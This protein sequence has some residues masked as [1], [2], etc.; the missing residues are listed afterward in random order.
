M[1]PRTDT[2][3][4]VAFASSADEPAFDELVRRHQQ[5]VFQTCLRMLGNV[6]EA[7]DAA[8]ATLIV[9]MKKA[10]TL[11]REGSLGGWLHAVA[12]RIAL[13]A[14]R[15]RNC[16]AKSQEA[17]AWQM[18]AC[19]AEPADV[20]AVLGFLDEELGRLS[21][22]QKQ[23][24][25]LR[26]LEGHSEKEAAQMAGCP[27]G[28]IGRRASDGIARL[29]LA[30]RGVTLGVSTL[31]GVLAVE[32]SATISETILPSLLT[33]VKSV[34]TTRATTT[35]VPAKA[36]MLA[37]GAMKAMFI[38]K[39]KMA[40]VVGLAIMGAAVGWFVTQS[41]SEKGVSEP[42]MPR[43]AVLVC[44][45]DCDLSDARHALARRGVHVFILGGNRMV[46]SPMMVPAALRCRRMPAR[47]YVE[48]IAADLGRRTVWLREGTVAILEQDVAANE[49]E[50]LKK[51]LA[52]RDIDA[53]R[54]AV[55]R[56]GRTYT[57]EAL[58]LLMA[59]AS[60]RE[61]TVA[62]EARDGLE[63]L[64]WG[65]ALTLDERAWPLFEAQ[66]ADP[67]AS[68]SSPEEVAMTG[69]PRSLAILRQAMQDR[70][71]RDECIR[72]L[73][74]VA[75]TEARRELETLLRD[76]DVDTRLCAILAMLNAGCETV[77][78]ALEKELREAS[79]YV[80]QQL[81]GSI[82]W[83]PLGRDKLSSEP[84]KSYLRRTMRQTTDG[85][86]RIMAGSSLCATGNREGLAFVTSI[87]RTCLDYPQETL[88]CLALALVDN[89]SPEALLL[90]KE[91]FLGAT[92]S[93]RNLRGRMLLPGSRMAPLPPRIFRGSYLRSGSSCPRVGEL[94]VISDR[95]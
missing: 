79:P 22:L 25:V 87:A 24:V 29:R 52:S 89:G 2:E 8:Q 45:R 50:D 67:F 88:Q 34:A 65:A 56:A 90:L 83:H 86:L 73:G 23:A 49:M 11:K 54:R 14:L 35:L 28:T 36:M 21:H 69:D 71:R 74:L 20:E 15:Q 31:A 57:V 63:H 46:Y 72:A 47:D 70:A 33:A 39:V 12:R 92:T 7:Q 94:C 77:I 93:A 43:K 37:K 81:S 62:Q 66:A 9:L 18:E 13:D 42:L 6:Q 51:G 1:E 44:L 4:I 75:G 41:V 60:D 95:R 10:G 59:A 3:L 58:R 5:M 55:E 27:V 61:P 78:P 19:T 85:R 48:A 32:A 40:A 64:G 80:R 76:G 68:W 17:A 82:A 16:Q 26:Y 84:V 91:T 30:R 38:A 53:R